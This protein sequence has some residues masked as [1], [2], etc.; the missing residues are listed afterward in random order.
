[1]RRGGEGDGRGFFVGDEGGDMSGRL[2]SGN[3]GVGV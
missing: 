3:E 1:M 2:G